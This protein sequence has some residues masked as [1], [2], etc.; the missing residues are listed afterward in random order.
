ML[1]V[2]QH[3]D[4]LKVC[5]LGRSYPPEFYSF[6]ENPKAR[7]VLERIAIETEEDYQKIISKLNE[8]GVKVIR[9]NIGESI[10]QHRN[11]ER[12]FQPPMTPRD[13]TIMLGNTFFMPGENFSTNW[14]DP[15]G[16]YWIDDDVLI[17]KVLNDNT[18]VE[19]RIKNLKDIV[20]T[21]P[22]DEEPHIKRDFIKMLKWKMRSINHNP[23]TTFP[24]NPQVDSFKD[25]REFVKSQG[26]RVEYDCYASGANIT[27]IGKDIYHGT[28]SVNE[29]NENTQFIRNWTKE[30]HRRCN[31]DYRFY[32]MDSDTHVDGTF[33]PI[34]PGLILSVFSME[35]YEKSFPGW[36]VVYLPDE[37]WNK[38]AEFTALKKKNKGKWWVPGEELNDDFT[39][40]V[41]TWLNDWVLYVEETVFDLNIL[42]IDENNVIVNGYSKPVFDAFQ[43]HNVT[44]HIVNFRHRY[45]W[46]GGLHCISSDLDREG[47]MVDYFPERPKSFGNKLHY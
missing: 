43:R 19:Q 10:E 35:K 46:D 16:E 21:I 22:P 32:M 26:N 18:T 40:F 1:S 29:S 12:Y 45:F 6:V 17:D 8:F 41:E 27:R 14:G 42:I 38:V 24:N 44:P 5:A 31:D 15:L 33:C 3:W 2:Y 4:P 23:L 20:N 47:E 39:D 37:S 28:V 13:H 7:S 30:V 11:E 9:N 34:K 36:E 25:I